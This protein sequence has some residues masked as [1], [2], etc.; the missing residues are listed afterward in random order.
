MESSAASTVQATTTSF[1]RFN[2]TLGR[3]A[4]RHEDS[5]HLGLFRL[6]VAGVLHQS[7]SFSVIVFSS[8]GHS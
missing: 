6:Q 4:L 8:F 2:I 1:S 7:L 5:D 3:E